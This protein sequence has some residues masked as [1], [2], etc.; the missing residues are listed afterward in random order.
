M[1]DWPS[2]LSATVGPLTEEPSEKLHRAL[3]TLDEGET[4]LLEPKPLDDTGKL[5][6]PGIKTGVKP[7]SSST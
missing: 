2:N 6:R 3:T 7:G 4:W 5:W 1:V